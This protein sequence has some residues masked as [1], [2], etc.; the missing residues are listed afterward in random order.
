[1]ARRGA[2]TFGV[3][4]CE[5]NIVGANLRRFAWQLS[6]AAVVG[7]ATSLPYPPLFFDVV[8]CGDVLEHVKQPD[9]ALR[10]IERVLRPGGVLWLAAPTRYLPANL[11]RDPHYGC[12]GVAALSR[13]T[14]AWYLARV[15]RRLPML[16]HYEVERLPTYGATVAAL[17]RL[18][19]EILSGEY[20]PL[21]A[22]R[23]PKRV[24]T[25]W[26]KRILAALL[27][28]GLRAPLI[29]FCRLAAELVCPIRIVCRKP[30]T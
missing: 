16:A 14:A 7:S 27:A 3:D 15:C 9:M 18:G 19:F 25:A 30:G 6:F 29:A 20:R 24:Q 8:T 10:E 1:M 17:R 28:I 22:L 5:G 26:K 21:A 23:D 4:L 13:Q 2:R 12:F 11:W